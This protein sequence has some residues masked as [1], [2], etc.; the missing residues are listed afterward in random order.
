MKNA[1]IILDTVR[2]P[3]AGWTWREDWYSGIDSSFGL[4][5]KFAMLNALSAREIAKIFVSANSGRRAA[6]CGRPD[7]DLRSSEVFDL[8][9]MSNIFRLHQTQVRSAFVQEILPDGRLRSSDH[10]RWCELCL[11]RGFHPAIFQVSMAAY[12]PIHRT[13]IRST[14]PHCSA[15]IPYRLRSDIFSKPFACPHCGI[16]WAPR[17]RAPRANILVPRIKEHGFVTK[18]QRFFQFEDRVLT[19]K[20]EIGKK[21]LQLAQ[22]EISFSPLERS[23]YISRYLG[24]VSHVLEETGYDKGSQQLHLNM[25]RVER[26]ERGVSRTVLF[27]DDDPTMHDSSEADQSVAYTVSSKSDAELA[28]LKTVYRAVR[29]RLWRQL[30]GTHRRCVVSAA[31]HL[32]WRVEGE[33]TASF[34]P[35]AEAFIRWRMIW[36][37]CGTPRYLF[38]ESDLEMYGIV[39]WLSARASPCP[40]HWSTATQIWV[41]AH[42]FSSACIESFR[43]LLAVA[44]QN[45][46]RGKT[47]WLR[48]R[49]PS[50]YDTYWAVG[51]ADCAD[52]PTY[53]YVRAPMPAFYPRIAE[54]TRRA[55]L[56]KHMA[57]LATIYR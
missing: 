33:I 24:F 3:V 50:R 47:Y 19:S 36:E 44:Q 20:L 17:L 46:E 40:P 13:A 55:H 22:G 8:D 5:L 48:Q 39:G 10:L 34:C 49:T 32:W 45:S 29:R 52:R 11:Q 41:L 1:R 27:E 37:G 43:E 57:H 9:E 7:V 51:G 2:P 54:D 53:V 21:A 28:R 26:C 23:G 35:V 18:L 25:E 56:E 30:V 14:C 15:E 16:D 31:Q 12:C 4:L 38:R 6:I 42:I